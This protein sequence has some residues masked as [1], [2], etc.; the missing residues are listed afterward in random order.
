[1]RNRRFFLYLEG[2]DMKKHI[3]GRQ[4]SRDT[5][6]RIALFKGLI[7]S[8]VMEEQIT[9]TQAKAKS[10]RGEVEK[11]ITKAKRK[12]Q[13]ARPQLQQWLQAEQLEKVLSDLAVR[14]ATR[15][16][17]YTRIITLGER[18]GDNATMA[19]IELVDRKTKELRSKTQESSKEAKSEKEQV[20]VV[21][22]APVK[23]KKETKL[24]KK[25]TKDTKRKQAE[26]KKN[27]KKGAK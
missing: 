12:G 4:L 24:T 20:E 2:L 6:E 7:N 9:T 19:V 10:I 14:Y 26:D 5:H 8:L 13:A 15:P 11:L 27:T 3:F 22:K 1:M 21:A 23:A 17:G 25:P 18:F 16:G